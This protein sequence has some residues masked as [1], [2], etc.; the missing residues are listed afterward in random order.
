MTLD[1]INK[2]KEEEKE[3]MSLYYHSLKGCNRTTNISLQ[4]KSWEAADS[5]WNQAKEI[6]KLIEENNTNS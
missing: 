2:L 4:L 6:R 1:E 5:Y 3:L